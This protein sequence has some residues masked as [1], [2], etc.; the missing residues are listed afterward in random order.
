MDTFERKFEI[1]SMNQLMPITTSR[2]QK[3]PLSTNPRNI[4]Y[5][6][7]AVLFMLLFAL[8]LQFKA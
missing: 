6:V 5:L 2:Q 3:G 7:A 1:T 4:A 8:S